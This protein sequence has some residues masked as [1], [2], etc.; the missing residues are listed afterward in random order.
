MNHASPIETGF[1]TEAS[2]DLAAFRAL[3]DQRTS[4]AD[5]PQADAI[6]ANIPLYDMDRLA[7]VL[8]DPG[9]RPALLAEWARVFLSGPG[10]IVLKGAYADTTPLDRATGIYLQIIS[11]EK[12]GAPQADHFAAAGSNDRIWNSLQ[13][14]C[15]ADAETYIDY[16]ANLAL[17]AASEAWLGP[18]YQT[19]AQVNLVHPGGRAQQA[20]R[21]YHLGF[22]TAEQ[23]ARFPAHV[24]QLSP[25]MTL[26]GGIAHCDIPVEAG[27]TKLLPFSQAYAPGYAAYRREDFRALFEERAVQLPLAKGDALFFNPALFHA[28]GD[29]RTPDIERMVNL[30][31]VSS[32]FGLPLEA[33]DRTTMSAQVFPHLTRRWQA[34]TLSEAQLDALI[35]AT[36]FGYPFSTNLDTDPPIGGL[37]P[38]SQQALL[39]A[40]V[41]ANQSP[42]ALAEDLA[43]Q[44]KKREA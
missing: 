44:M 8:T 29:N 30:L 26:Q 1:Y 17:D 7:P 36:A 35:A 37:A 13:K 15:A 20:H 25:L 19:T 43:L 2:C 16:F 9:L 33:V 14:L 10:V 21:D 12:E 4:P 40:A 23:C 38:Q 39:K 28:A 11:C 31:Q 22:Q 24:H 32:A 34:G 6:E 3:V 42:E 27:P 41:L 5:V 18:A